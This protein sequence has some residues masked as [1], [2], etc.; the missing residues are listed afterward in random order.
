M[1]LVSSDKGPHTGTG[2]RVLILCHEAV[3]VNM[4]GPAIRYWEI[5]RALAYRF[6]VRLAHPSLEHAV[7]DGFSVVG[8]ARG[9]YRSLAAHMYCADVVVVY[10]YVLVGLPELADC[11][12]PLVVDLYDVFVIEELTYHL[13][14]PAG[15][16]ERAAAD[17]V[18]ILQAVLQAGD[19]F[20]CSSERQRDF[21]LG[22]LAAEGRLNPRTLGADQSLRSLIDVVP[23]GIPTDPPEHTAPVLKGVHPRISASDRV[24]LWGGGLWDWFDPL[25]LIRAMAKVHEKRPDVKLYFLARQHYSG[26]NLAPMQAGLDAVNLARELALLDECVFFGEWV[27]YADR[28]NYLLEADLG[29]SLHTAGLETHFAFRTRL[30][31]CIWAGLPILATSGDT[32]GEL[33]ATA[34]LGKVVPCDD[35]DAVATGI[36]SL[37][38]EDDLRA[39]LAPSFAAAGADLMWDRAVEPLVRFLQRPRFAPDR[40]PGRSLNSQKKAVRAGAG[41]KPTPYL[42]LPIKALRVLRE[43]GL[44]SLRWE[45]GR[46]LNWW[47]LYRH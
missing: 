2:P 11:G 10:G 24:L 41:I 40:E 15:D 42:A 27:P 3:G 5:A 8:Y 4:S 25:T 39:R 19:F 28:G 21:W 17:Q 31:D 33:V 22:T 45:I 12:K 44:S 16:Q 1:A 18:A 13:R 14:L 6:D 23:F 38:A 34:G 36:L 30:L 43:G 26:G 37:L 9:D 46:Y 35:A 29:V 7:G 32:L 20:L 47:K